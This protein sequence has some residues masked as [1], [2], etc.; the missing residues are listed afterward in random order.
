[1]KYETYHANVSLVSSTLIVARIRWTDRCRELGQN[2]VWSATYARS[3]G[4]GATQTDL[5]SRYVVRI[6]AQTRDDT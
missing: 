2:E 5:V 6:N 4:L 1:V 3:D